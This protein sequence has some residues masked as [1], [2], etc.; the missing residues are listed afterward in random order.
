MLLHPYFQIES[1]REQPLILDHQLG[2]NQIQKP[3]ALNDNSKQAH[4]MNWYKKNY[5]F[6]YELSHQ[7][8]QL[9]A[10]ILSIRVDSIV[11]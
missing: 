5:T 11:F 1:D 2:K 3:Y 10:E 7:H 9:T 6:S 4:L 8:V